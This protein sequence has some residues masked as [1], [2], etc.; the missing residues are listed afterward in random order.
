MSDTIKVPGLRGELELNLKPSTKDKEQFVFK[1]EGVPNVRTGAKGSFVVQIKMVHP[2]K[3][4]DEQ[5]ELVEKLH[6]SFGF[7]GKPHEK[8]YEG[9]FDKIKH[10]FGY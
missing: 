7:E 1:N 8:E 3:L 2:S 9:L 6:T 10:W 5:K 4:S